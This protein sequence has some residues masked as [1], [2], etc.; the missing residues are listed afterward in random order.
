MGMRVLARERPARKSQRVCGKW[1]S[2]PN[3]FMSVSVRVRIDVTVR[4]RVNMCSATRHSDMADQ[5]FGARF[6]DADVAARVELHVTRLI[7][8]HYRAQGGRLV[9]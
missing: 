7:Q 8:T 1:D 5:I 2:S 3:A 9:L 4:A 6:T